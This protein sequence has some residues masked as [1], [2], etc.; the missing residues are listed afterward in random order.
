MPAAAVSGPR[1]AIKLFTTSAVKLI[2]I[3]LIG[4]EQED[5][6]PRLLTD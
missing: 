4:E 2:D 1:Y 6:L 5:S 3:Q